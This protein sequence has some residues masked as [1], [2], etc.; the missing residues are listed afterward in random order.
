MKRLIDFFRGKP[1]APSAPPLRNKPGGMAWVRGINHG[2]GIESING[3]AVQSVRI[4]RGSIWLIEPNIRVTFSR[5][6]LYQ[7]QEV[8]V[9]AGES[10]VIDGVADANLVPWKDAD[11]TDE[12]VR[13]LYTTKQPEAA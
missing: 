7:R 13:E 4:L 5:D 3:A 6:T 10:Y 2:N 1:Q 11:L 9:L 12:E 8:L